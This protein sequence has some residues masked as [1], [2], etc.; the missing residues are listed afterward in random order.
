MLGDT[1]SQIS[2]TLSP[3]ALGTAHKTDDGY[4]FVGSL[5][6]AIAFAQ[7]LG[8]LGFSVAIEGFTIDLNPIVDYCEAELGIDAVSSGVDN[9]WT[10]RPD[11]RWTWSTDA[12]FYFTHEDEATAFALEF[13]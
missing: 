5:Y 13:L 12:V 2:T 1:T 10:I 7:S 6:R 11:A 9:S 4:R 8:V 3:S